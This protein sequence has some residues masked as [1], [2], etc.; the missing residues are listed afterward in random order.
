MRQHEAQRPHDVRRTAQQHLTFLQRLG[1]QREL[2]GLQVA[3]AA[4]D[5]LGGA[6]GGVLRQVLAFGQQHAPAAAGE[7]PRQPRAVDAAP[8]HHDVKIVHI[9]DSK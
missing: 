7:V 9:D 6:G 3:Q 2:V 8:D 5:E 1:H 4:V